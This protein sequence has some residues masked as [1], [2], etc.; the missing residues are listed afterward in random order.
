MD[1]LDERDDIDR[2]ITGELSNYTN[3]LP[4]DGQQEAWQQ[5]EGRLFRKKPVWCRPPFRMLAASVVAVVVLVMLLQ[6]STGDAWVTRR[7]G[8]Y[9][10]K[11]TDS[12]RNLILH[13]TPFS[14]HQKM[15]IPLLSQIEFQPLVVFPGTD[16]WSLCDV[17]LQPS[18]GDDH[19]LV[20]VYTDSRGYTYTLSQTNLDS[21]QSTGWFYDADDARLSK[22]VVGG[23]SVHLLH[24]K[25]GSSKA[26]WTEANL[27][28][29]LESS[30]SEETV[31]EFIGALVQYRAD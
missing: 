6:S 24:F 18:G 13:E 8:V 17:T 11:V 1:T 7:L 5:I 16:S 27:S 29:T 22:H 28:L 31:L 2:A 19:T 10:N 21:N 30:A 25:D 26:V 23:E 12:V 14:T 3:S 9:V 4:V 20:L 15:L